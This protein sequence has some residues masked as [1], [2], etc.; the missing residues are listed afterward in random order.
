[1]LTHCK[2]YNDVDMVPYW[3]QITAVIMGLLTGIAG[4][5]LGIANLY[6][7]W[8]DRKTNLEVWYEPRFPLGSTGMTIINKSQR[9]ATVTR[10][11]IEAKSE[12]AKE[13][14]DLSNL[15]FNKDPL[16]ARIAAEDSLQVFP[17]IQL[18]YERLGSHGH[19]GRTKVVPVVE[20]GVG[21]FHRA[22]SSFQITISKKRE[23][24]EDLPG[25]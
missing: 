17:V 6:L 25:F 13:L 18:V 4:T 3:L 15:L 11:Y 8:T 1:M 9:E 16:P 5:V 12:T 21:N 24:S 10:F 20:D 14:L 22:K 2:P 19:S 23:T 7:R